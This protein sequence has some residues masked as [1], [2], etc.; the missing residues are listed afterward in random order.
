MDH[1]PLVGIIFLVV[2]FVIATFIARQFRVARDY[3]QQRPRTLLDKLTARGTGAMNTDR[4]RE[5]MLDSPEGSSPTAETAPGGFGEGA[6]AAAGA[7][8]GENPEE[9]LFSEQLEIEGHHLNLGEKSLQTIYSE[10]LTQKSLSPFD[11]EPDFRLGV[12]YLKFGQFD[13]A[14]AQFQKV[15]DSKPGFPGVFYYLGEAYRCNGQFYEAMRAY[16]R[17]WEQD[18]PNPEHLAS[19]SGERLS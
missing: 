12:A 13:K 11:P 3:Q 5:L 8:P 18:R 15:A 1:L 16:K 14:Q 7:A 19:E 4:F 9:G 10:Y 17:S 2:L 6:S